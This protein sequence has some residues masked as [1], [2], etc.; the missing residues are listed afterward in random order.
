MSFSRRSEF[1]RLFTNFDDETVREDILE[2]RLIHCH[3]FTVL[4]RIFLHCLPQDSSQW[5]Q[6]LRITRDEYTKLRRKYSID[7]HSISPENGI[8]AIIDHPLSQDPNVNSGLL[9]SHPPSSSFRAFGDSITTTQ[10]SRRV[11]RSMLF[12]RTESF[13]VDDG[14]RFNL[15]RFL[16]IPAWPFFGTSAR[17]NSKRRSYSLTLGIT[18]QLVNIDRSP[19]TIHR[20]RSC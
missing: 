2:R 19:S 14:Y 18:Q 20:C 7:P 12:E 16:V 13:L 3:F 15:W 5:D 6:R 9:P 1:E 4:W 11:S 10:I 17:P 8:C